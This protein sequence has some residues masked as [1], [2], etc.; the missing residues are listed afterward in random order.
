MTNLT[1]LAFIIML[2]SVVAAFPA[3]AKKKY[4]IL[5]S[6]QSEGAYGPCG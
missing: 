3:D 5:Y 6:G 1:R 4:H 2:L